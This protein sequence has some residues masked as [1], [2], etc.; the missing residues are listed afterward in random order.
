VARNQEDIEAT[1][2]DL[3]DKFGANEGPESGEAPGPG[4]L[5]EEYRI[6]A[7]EQVNVPD[8]HFAKPGID[9]TAQ[10]EVSAK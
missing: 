5:T 2:A 1:R 6:V 10:A 7:S 8:H 4:S 3:E 9:S